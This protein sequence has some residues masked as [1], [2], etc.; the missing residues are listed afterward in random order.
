MKIVWV[1]LAIVG[2]CVLV[3]AWH[4]VSPRLPW[5]ELAAKVHAKRGMVNCGHARGLLWSDGKGDVAWHAVMN[6]AT[7]AQGAGKGFVAAFTAPYGEGDFSRALVVDGKGKGMEIFYSTGMDEHADQFM[8]VPCK[9]PLRLLVRPES[10]G[11]RDLPRLD[12]DYAV[13]DAT[14]DWLFW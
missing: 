10:W 8:K 6:C 13:S 5:I 4:R 1:G 3:F 7:T 2:L 12:C 14:R 9:T 11:S